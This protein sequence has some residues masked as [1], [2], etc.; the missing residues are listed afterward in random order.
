[1]NELHRPGRDA[2]STGAASSGYAPAATRLAAIGLAV[3]A[4]LAFAATLLAIA[5][6][7]FVI[8]LASTGAKPAVA[9]S[10][11]RG[12]ATLANG[13]QLVWKANP[14]GSLLALGFS[15]DISVEGPETTLTGRFF[16]RGGGAT[17]SGIS[18]RAP[19]SLLR[20]T[21][22]DLSLSCSLNIRLDD[23]KLG[24]GRQVMI[25]GAAAS[26]AGTCTRSAGGA[27]FDVPAARAV[28]ETSGGASTTRVVSAADPAVI[29]A[30]ALLE[31]DGGVKVTVMPAALKL[32][33]GMPA[34]GPAVYE[35]QAP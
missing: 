31:A 20:S 32:V 12:S 30:E 22:P 15:A 18:G 16:T 35:M 10:L 21:L 8:G 9:G 6:A 25:S 11:W 27:R 28:A 23:V 2:S 1:M 14:L 33:P 13:D 19:W 7:Q 17:V 4:L 3:F 5:P 24:L 34:S 29:L 26:N